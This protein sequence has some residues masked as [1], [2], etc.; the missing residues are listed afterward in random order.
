MANEL[1]PGYEI[2]KLTKRESQILVSLNS[3]LNNKELAKSLCVSEGTLK[4]H[5]HNIYGKL[6]VRNRVGA[7]K[8]AEVLELSC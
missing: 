3:D 7:I 1:M 4:W 8:K 6:G 2:E 5:L